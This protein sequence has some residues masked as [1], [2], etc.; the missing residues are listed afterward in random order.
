MTA[1]G[2]GRIEGGETWTSPDAETTQRLGA[3]VAER[4]SPGDVIA[5]Y[6]ALGAGKTQW[7]KGFSRGLGFTGVVASPTFNLIHEYPARLPVYHFDLYRLESAAELEDLDCDDYFFGG[8]VTVIEWAEKAGPL[9]PPRRWEVVIET[10]DVSR[11]RIT[12]YPPRE[13]H[14]AC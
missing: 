11:R 7:V 9:L 10:M 14:D 6:G 8:G 5:L 13:V 4:V 2:R 1:H 12:L 3:A